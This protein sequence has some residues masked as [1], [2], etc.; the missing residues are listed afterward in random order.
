M[1]DLKGRRVIITGGASGIGRAAAELISAR[2]G[3][4]VVLDVDE[5]A[6]ADL[7][8]TATAAGHHL[9]FVRADVSRAADAATAVATAL[10]RSAVSMP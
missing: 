1:T 6:G 10:E 7:T 5:R 9:A 2:D 8:R 4:V 3:R